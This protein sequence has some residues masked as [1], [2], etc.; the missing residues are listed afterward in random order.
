M[1]PLWF[2]MLALAVVL[3]ASFGLVI[4]LIGAISN[5]TLVL[6]I[7][8]ALVAVPVLLF[9]VTAVVVSVVMAV[10]SA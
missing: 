9:I 10:A 8:V 2:D 4:A 3:S 5:R 6:S 7:G 1:M